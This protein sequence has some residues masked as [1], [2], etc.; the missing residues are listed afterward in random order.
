MTAIMVAAAEAMMVGRKM[1]EKA[2]ARAII[3]HMI[4]ALLAATRATIF[5]RAYRD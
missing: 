5:G 3:A 1:G 4:T 2:A